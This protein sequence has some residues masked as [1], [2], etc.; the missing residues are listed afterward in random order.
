MESHCPMLNTLSCENMIIFSF[1]GGWGGGYC[2]VPASFCHFPYDPERES[3]GHQKKHSASASEPATDVFKG[4]RT[5]RRRLETKGH[6]SIHT[7]IYH[8]FIFRI[9]KSA[10]VCLWGFLEAVE[11]LV[12]LGKWERASSGIWNSRLQPAFLWT[13]ADPPCLLV[14]SQLAP[15][16]YCFRIIKSQMSRLTY[17]AEPWEEIAC[18]YEKKQM[19]IDARSYKTCSD[20]YNSDSEVL[21][22]HCS[23]K[24]V[25][26]SPSFKVCWWGYLSRCG[27]NSWVSLIAQTFK[28]EIMRRSNSN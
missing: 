23:L 1:F 6:I 22:C 25:I 17:K 15:L 9:F 5:L 19:W 21:V 4:W 11:K 14:C 27:E 2:F 8:S 13:H 20:F 16:S 26:F 24:I 3:V 28:Y 10:A 7:F 18:C 12:G